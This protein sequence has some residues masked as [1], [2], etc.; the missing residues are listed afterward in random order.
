MTRRVFSR[1]GQLISCRKV[2]EKRSGRRG[3]ASSSSNADST[4]NEHWKQLWRL[5][6]P[7]KIR[8]DL[9]R[10]AHNSLAARRN[11]ER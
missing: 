6:C 1:S 7:G 2:Y 11:L 4:D 9:W 3:V 5:K 10:F 8:H